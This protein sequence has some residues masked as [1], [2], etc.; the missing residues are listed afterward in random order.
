VTS[1]CRVCCIPPANIGFGRLP[2]RKCSSPGVTKVGLTLRNLC[3]VDNGVKG[4]VGCQARYAQVRVHAFFRQ[5]DVMFHHLWKPPGAP[6]PIARAGLPGSIF[7][8][9]DLLG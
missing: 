1:K 4:S 6:G 2:L 5:L 9:A 3:F 8:S 7:A